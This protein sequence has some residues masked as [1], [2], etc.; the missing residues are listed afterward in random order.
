VRER[1]VVPLAQGNVGPL[2]YSLE[3]NAR[4]GHPWRMS[5][6]LWSESLEFLV[7][8]F[9]LDLAGTQMPSDPSLAAFGERM[10][11]YVSA[12]DRQALPSIVAGVEERLAGVRH[13]QSHG[14]FWSENFLVREGRLETVLDW[15]WAARDA[16]PLLDLFDPIA[17]SR[18][19]VR[20]FTPGE[21]FTEVLWPLV[22]AGGDERIH[23][24]CRAVG[25]EP[26]LETLEGLAVAYWLNRVA[27]QLHPLAVFPQRAGWAER[28]LHG[29]IQRLVAA[30]W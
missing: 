8:L 29:P 16:L 28:N 18:R 30:G 6:E 7:A 20:D 23:S 22:R 12:E 17:L 14:D 1:L 3:P 13:G 26:D 25:M 4:G 15:E 2:R 21:R 11:D 24:Y 10:A 5:N 9:G 19:R 27:R